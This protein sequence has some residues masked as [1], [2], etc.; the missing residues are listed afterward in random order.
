MT[1]D[2]PAFF[3]HD[4]EPR[5]DQAPHAFER[6]RRAADRA[7]GTGGGVPADLVPYLEE[8][9]TPSEDE[10]R[11]QS[12]EEAAQSGADA[13]EAERTEALRQLVAHSLLLGPD[14]SILEEIEDDEDTEDGDA[15]TADSE[16][17]ATTGSPSSTEHERTTH[18]EAL[19]AATR[20]VDLDAQVDAVYRQIVARAPEHRVQPSLE[21]VREVLDMIGNPQDAYP[22]LHITGTNGKTSTA[23]MA[24]AILT[25]LGLRVGR[26]T[27]P[28]LS[29][30]RERISLGGEP[31]SREGFLAAWR[32]VAPYIDLEDAQSLERGGPRLSF[33]EVFTVMAFAAF[34]DA[35]VDAAVVEVGMG[36]EWDATNVMHG[37]VAAILPID[38]DHQKWL[39]ST[40]VEIATEKA[41]IIKPRQTVV[42][43]RQPEEALEILLDRAREVDAVVRLEDRDFEVVD[44]QM[45]VGGQMVTIRTPAAVYEDVFVPLLGEHQAHNAAVALVSAEAFLGG[46]ALDAA[47]VD[48]GFLSASSPGRLEVVRTSPSIV[49]D[50]AH[51]PAGARTLRAALE[52]SFDFAHIVGVFSAM[53]DKDVEGIL[54]EVE[55]VLDQLVVTTMPGPRAMPADRL[56]AIA[57]DVF[58]PDR[59]ELREDLADAVYRAVELAE[60]MTVPVSNAGVVTFGSIVLAGAARAL[61]RPGR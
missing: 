52:D 45:G 25:A 49:V 38:L 30:V 47:V 46:R 39:G 9:D 20:D 10:A 55:P 27:S 60:G 5:A 21:R 57:R 43:A 44:R 54:G 11:S 19:D 24:D 12:E 7:G 3:G 37:D 33:F 58:G 32:D 61:L 4:H 40:L 31:I 14:P 56:V 15:G 50:A 1:T 36:G 51:N 41:G 22:S 18:A 6:A 34:A 13:Q 16:R 23:R 35:P 29:D 48:R 59:V 26:F 28:H 2:H 8:A 17:D 53:G 42:I